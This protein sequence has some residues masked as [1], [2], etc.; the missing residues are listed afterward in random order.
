MTMS[1]ETNESGA[2]K[3]KTKHVSLYQRRRKRR[4][5]EIREKDVRGGEEGGVTYI[6]IILEAGG[7]EVLW[8]ENKQL[9]TRFVVIG[10]LT[11]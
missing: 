5:E 3:N 2:K 10:H 11:D 9:V 8:R 1:E 7:V 4:K 6:L